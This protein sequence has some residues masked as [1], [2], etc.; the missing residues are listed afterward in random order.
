MLK[1]RQPTTVVDALSA[2]TFSLAASRNGCEGLT[3]V[4]ENRGFARR[5][6]IAADDD[7]DVKR[8][9]LDAIANPSRI[10]GGKKGRPGGCESRA[11]PN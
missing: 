3:C 7:I 2:H 4:G 11:N 6:L 5:R 8:I 1:R 9:E 10:L